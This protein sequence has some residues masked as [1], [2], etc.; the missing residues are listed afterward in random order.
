MSLKDLTKDKHAIAENTKF[1]KAVFARTLPKLLWQDFT[2]QK[3]IWYR[4]IENA[5]KTFGLLENLP[6]IERVAKLNEDYATILTKEPKTYFVVKSVATDYADYIKTLNK[7]QV[8]AHLYVWH[9]G[10]MMGG[11]MIKKII[12]DEPTTHL[13]FD[14]VPGLLKN[15]RPMLSDELADEAN[16]A[17]DWA[18]KIL[19]YYDS[20]LA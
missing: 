7:D 4:E 3:F 9:V 19:E 17:F 14:D 18:I 8:L 12:T 16:V 15:L 10:D 5:A 20:G 13:D 2:F 6:G 11:Q 1:M